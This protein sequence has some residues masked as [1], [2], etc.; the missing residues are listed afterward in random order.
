MAAAVGVTGVEASKV[1]DAETKL[2]KVL[3]VEKLE[4]AEVMVLLDTAMPLATR[5][6]AKPVVLEVA[7]MVPCWFNT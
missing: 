6:R 1:L 7:T 4:V 2:G 3:V 5:M